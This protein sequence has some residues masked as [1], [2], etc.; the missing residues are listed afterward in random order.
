[1]IDNLSLAIATALVSGDELM[2][3]KL[4]TDNE[5]KWNKEGWIS[6]AKELPFDVTSIAFSIPKPIEG[7]HIYSSRSIDLSGVRLP[8]ED[9]DTGI[10]AL[11][12]S[13]ANNEMFVSLIKQLREN[14]EIRIFSDLL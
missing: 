14:A 3:N 9:A 11:Y 8:E 10:A 12:M 6:R 4:L 1:M 5:L 2:T 13:Q 7:E